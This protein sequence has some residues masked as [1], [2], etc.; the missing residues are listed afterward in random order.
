MTTTLDEIR[1]GVAPL[2]ESNRPLLGPCA[3]CGARGQGAPHPRSACGVAW[4]LHRLYCMLRER[5]VRTLLAA[6][7]SVIV[8]FGAPTTASAGSEGRVLF[9]SYCVACHGADARGDGPVAAKLRTQP[10]DLTR[11][12][13]RFGTPINRDK[14][15]RYIDGRV[16]V[17]AHGPRNMPV[18]GQ[19]LQDELI[20]LP[21]TEDTIRR[22]IDS[23]VDY[24]VSIQEIR[25][26]V[27]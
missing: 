4:S 27:R 2:S 6:A 19:R 21:A 25:G 20:G 3:R 15:A 1:I 13:R 8:L 23:I 18:W 7:A 9:G 24:L 10:S 11:L 22:T 14:V 16:D 17:L 5:S 26:A 12:G